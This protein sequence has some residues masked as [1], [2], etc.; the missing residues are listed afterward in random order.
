MAT[1]VVPQKGPSRLGSDA[2]SAVLRFGGGVNSRASPD[3]IDPR[4]CAAGTNFVLDAGNTNLRNRPPFDLKATA[5][6]GE[7]INGF[8]TLRTSGD[9]ISMLVQAGAAVYQFDGTSFG[10]QVGTVNS[11]ARLRGRLSHNFELD[12][13]VI[14]TDLAA[15]EAVKTWDGSSFS[16]MTH[17]LTGDFVA[18]YCY[19]SGARAFYGNVISN[20][21][22]TPHLVVGSGL[23]DYNDLSVSDRPSSAL[24]SA[25]PFYITTQD[26]RPVNGLVASFGLL[27]FSSRGGSIYVLEGADATDYVVNELH[28]NSGATGSEGVA[29]IGNDVI[30]GRVGVIESLIA[31]DR[32]GDVESNDISIKI[33]DQID[34]FDDW[35]IAYN[36]RLQRVYCYPENQAEIWV[37]HKTLMESEVSPWVRWTTQHESSFN[38]TAMMTCLDPADGLEKVFFGD[39]SGN[40]YVMEGTGS[41]DAGSADIAT[42]RLSGLLTVPLGAQMFELDGWLTYRKNE[43]ATVTLRFEYAGETVFNE[44]ITITLPAIT[45]DVYGGNSYYGG[46]SFYGAPFANRLTRRKFRTPGQSEM[47]Q[48][49]VTVEGQTDIEI[50]EIGLRFRAAG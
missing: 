30:Y 12:D 44:D 39:A 48:V 43:A 2:T 23:E 26:L 4:E 14:I 29:F 27:M 15:Q 45:G 28:P 34:G 49:R 35:V 25:D 47:L 32:F 18:R 8:A 3:E 36:Q 16:T 22:A 9:V 7:R 24:G 21:A 20:S 42:E 38:P 10:A 31:T 40:L 50:N 1:R 33:A 46:D 5:P 17:N 19:V 11:A 13:L 41:G 6:N 37:L